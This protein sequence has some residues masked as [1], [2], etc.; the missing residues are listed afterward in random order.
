MAIF[1]YD[2]RVLLAF[3][4]DLF[5]GLISFILAIALRFSLTPYN[6]LDKTPSIWTKVSI[7]IFIQA[8]IFI[9]FGLYRG[10]WRFSSTHDLKQIIKASILT[11]ITVFLTFHLTNNIQGFPRSSFFIYCCLLILSTGGGRFIYRIIKESKQSLHGDHTLIIGAGNAGEQLIRDI[12][13]CH[14]TKYKVLGF[15]D[16]N[17]RLKGRSIHGLRVIGQCSNLPEI[18][19]RFSITKVFI[20]IPS[21]TSADL[22]R[23]ITICESVD[24]LQVKILPSV[25]DIIDGNVNVSALREV[26]LDD[27]LGRDPI[28]LDLNSIGKMLTDKTVLISGAGGSIGSELAEQV[29]KF[30][31][32]H[33][34]LLDISEYFLYEIDRQLKQKFSDISIIPIVADIRSTQR[35]RS[36]LKKY[37]PHIIYHAAAYKQVPLMETN[38]IEAYETNI[39]GTFNLA[40]EA[41]SAKV[42]R[43]VMVSTDK[44]VNPTSIMGATKRIAEM[45]CQ[46]MS[47]SQTKF[48]NVRFGNVLGSNGSVIPLFEEQIKNGGPV[49]VTHK[50]ITRYFMSIPEAA[51]LILQA[52]S[53]GYGGEIFI[54]DMGE[55]IKIYDL[56]VKM[57]YLCGLKPFDDI[58]IKITGL[59]PGEKLY[60]ELLADEENT[61]KTPHPSVRVACARNVPDKLIKQIKQTQTKLYEMDQ[62][63]IQ[64]MLKEI[65]TEYTP[66]FK[67]YD[68]N[69][70]SIPFQ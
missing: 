56:A 33:L 47:C 43:F 63:E 37:S 5:V 20:A 65:V 12:K 30:K 38:H 25:A 16:D 58:D 2:F 42:E 9:L 36:L 13:R 59:R 46:E 62:K 11:T 14:H 40:Q 49:T 67:N 15:I 35:I 69:T 19:K 45:I 4:H 21:A 26:K 27:L 8:S 41:I 28:E 57:I 29:C 60:E 66:D 51:Q 53:M 70:T 31:P 64:I 17:T 6:F 68:S 3:G 52:G 55:P 61:L 32:N 34:I 10:V 39:M 22:R 44:A 50:E 7:V 1:K 23:I 18:A 48:T 54:L 24:N